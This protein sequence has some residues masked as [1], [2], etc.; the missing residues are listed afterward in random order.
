[1][2]EEDV[3]TLV[4]PEW[5]EERLDEPDLRV[6]DCTVD[7]TYNNETGEMEGQSGLDDWKESHIPGSVF[8][9]LIDDLSKTDDPDY[10]FQLP[11]PEH[12]AAE[13]ESVGIGDD[14]QVVAYDNARDDSSNEWAARFWWML[15]VFG[16]NQVGV[17]NGG[18]KRWTNENRATTSE[19]SSTS[20]V[21]F[22]PDF[23]PELVTDKEEVLE[24]ISDESDEDACVVNA[25]GP[26]DYESVRI[27][28]TK[29]V[30]SVGE[31]AVI[32]TETNTY[33]SEDEIREQFGKAG[34]TEADKVV[35]HCGAGI[36]ASSAA[37]AAH[38]AG[39]ENVAVYDGSLEEWRTDPNV[40]IISND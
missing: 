25:L 13:M 38:V 39:I 4:E 29:N 3:P 15:R 40:P 8:V 21:T 14:T 26:D 33:V 30:P 34:A 37:L 20:D 9:D 23:H 17:L 6:V 36:A 27:P 11:T 12:F 24:Y 19:T 1:M 16:H 28:N 5:L 22:T 32:D 10:S 18:W 31:S 2:A 7:L 35:T